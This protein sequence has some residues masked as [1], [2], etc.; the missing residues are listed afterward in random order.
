MLDNSSDSVNSDCQIQTE[1]PGKNFNNFKKDS[2]DSI[3]MGSSWL[4]NGDGSPSFDIRNL[5]EGH[6]NTRVPNPLILT[7]N[8]EGIMTPMDS[9]N[10][11]IVEML[12]SIK[13]NV[14]E[15]IQPKVNMLQNILHSLINNVKQGRSEENN[16]TSFSCFSFSSH[17]EDEVSWQNSKQLMSFLSGGNGGV[18][19]ENL[20]DQTYM[21]KQSVRSNSD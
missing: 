14:P 2:L 6:N 11:N 1:K 9:N 13:D 4:A 7:E 21:S 16:T 19:G 17:K 15:H 18:N 3:G 10:H 20:L 8:S 5:L 12:N